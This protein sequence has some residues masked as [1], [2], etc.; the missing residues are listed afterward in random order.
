MIRERLLSAIAVVAGVGLGAGLALGAGAG[1]DAGAPPAP[2]S[3]PSPVVYP[4]QA[5]P[6]RFDH[7]Q[8]ARLGARCEVCHAAALSSAAATDNL[9]PGEAACRPCH[10][11]DRTQ[12]TKAVAPGQGAARCDAC[13]VAGVGAGWQPAA[14]LAEPPRVR[15]ARPNLKFNHKL[16]ASRGLCS[17]GM[18]TRHWRGRLNRRGRVPRSS[19][20]SWWSQR[21]ATATSKRPIAP[22]RPRCSTLPSRTR[23][24]ARRSR[25]C[26]LVWRRTPECR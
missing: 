19:R 24:S 18:A 26:L 2:E 6:L 13:H 23:S 14:A 7:A 25:P 16:H 17:G 22:R 10:A 11:I 21:P 20:P 1:A 15:L 3:A 12:P 5:I 9:I 8:H 4:A